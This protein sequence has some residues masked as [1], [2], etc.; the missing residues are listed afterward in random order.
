[1][2]VGGPQRA[3]EWLG[4]LSAVLQVWREKY[5][6]VEVLQSVVE[7]KPADTLVKAASGAELLVVGDRLTDRR[8]I[9]RT[10][11]VTHAVIH[12]VGCPVV[13][14]PHD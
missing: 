3:E 9:P 7:G 2:L 12:R 8:G 1:G 10:G 6:E 4:F 14:V 5:P 13:I 11:P